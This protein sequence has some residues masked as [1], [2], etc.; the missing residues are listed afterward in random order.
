MWFV[1]GIMIAFGFMAAL[2]LLDIMVTP[3]RSRTRYVPKPKHPSTEE[4]WIPEDKFQNGR[5][6]TRRLQ[7]Q[8]TTPTPASS[9]LEPW[10]TRLLMPLARR[11]QRKIFARK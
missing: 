8:S 9:N 11:V 2:A 3:S 1:R 6:V 5:W 7:T 10:P 4:V